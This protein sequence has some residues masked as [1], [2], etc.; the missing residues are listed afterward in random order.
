MTVSEEFYYY[1]NCTILANSPTG[2]G[3]RNADTYAMF[4]L[5]KSAFCYEELRL[6]ID[7]SIDSGRRNGSIRLVDWYSGVNGGSFI[8]VDAHDLGRQ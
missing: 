3:I 1:T 6:L 4:A 2:Y 5:C 7:G 8:V